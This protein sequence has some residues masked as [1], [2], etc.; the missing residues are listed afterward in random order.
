MRPDHLGERGRRIQSQ[1]FVCD[2]DRTIEVPGGGVSDGKHIERV[3]VAAHC[4]CDRAVGQ[5]HG[6]F[7]IPD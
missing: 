2:R 6:F 4:Q 3:G 7:G 1:R 5:L